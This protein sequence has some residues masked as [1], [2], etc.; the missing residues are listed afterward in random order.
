MTPVCA[1][2]GLKQ[3]SNMI[4]RTFGSSTG[5]AEPSKRKQARPGVRSG[6]EEEGRPLS[7][8]GVGS[9]GEVGL[10]DALHL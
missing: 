6:L 2:V 9:G 10:T 1:F 3:G 8:G 7:G 5:V 4:S